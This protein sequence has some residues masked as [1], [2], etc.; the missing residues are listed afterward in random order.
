MP[1]KPPIGTVIEMSDGSHS[2]FDGKNFVPATQAGGQ[3]AVDRQAMMSMGIGQGAPVMTDAKADQ[4]AIEADRTKAATSLNTALQA[5]RFLKLN[6]GKNTGGWLG[7]PLV[8]GFVRDNATAGDPDYAQ[9][10]GIT[11]AVAPG[12]RPPGSGSSSDKDVQF[13]RRGFPNIESP[14]QSNVATGRRLQEQSD[15]DAAYA[16]WRDKWFQVKGSLLGADTAFNQYWSKKTQGGDPY[17]DK[18]AALKARSANR[19]PRLLGIED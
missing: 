9:M 18:G 2:I 3:W 1:N 7:A 6:A 5:Q 15:R 19:Q 10:E 12:L 13:Y 14:Y 17:I 4:A 16:A 11:S 8:G